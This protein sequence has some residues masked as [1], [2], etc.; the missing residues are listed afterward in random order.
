LTQYI[1]DKEKELQQ[2]ETWAIAQ[3]GEKQPLV[4]SDSD[5]L[6]KFVQELVNYPTEVVNANE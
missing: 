3:A 6:E 2:K 5:R 1:W 4:V